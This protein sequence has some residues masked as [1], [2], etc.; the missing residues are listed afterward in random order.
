[1]INSPPVTPEQASSLEA[2]AQETAGSHEVGTATLPCRAWKLRVTVKSVVP[3]HP[4]GRVTV[5]GKITG[6]GEGY[7]SE[8]TMMDAE[9]SPAVEFKGGGRFT[10]SFSGSADKWDPVRPISISVSP[11]VEPFETQVEI[12]PKKPW[13]IINVVNVGDDKIVPKFALALKL[14]T[15]KRLATTVLDKPSIFQEL[16]TAESDGQVTSIS[17]A[18]NFDLGSL[19]HPDE[20]WELVSISEA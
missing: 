17:R 19:E 5:S 12:K 9:V 18:R 15:N 13:V 4:E 20:V 2:S 3:F 6:G 7:E 8:R 1:M 14:G 16:E 10:W 11:R